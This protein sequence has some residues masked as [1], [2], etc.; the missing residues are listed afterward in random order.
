MGVYVYS[1]KRNEDMGK[2][3]YKRKWNIEKPEGYL[4]AL[5]T[6]LPVV[7]AV[8][9]VPL[10]MGQYEN[11]NGLMKYAWFNGGAVDYDFFL[12]W[13]SVLLSLLAFVM[14][15]CVIRR[16]VKEKKKA[17]FVKVFL[18]L[19][20]Y[21][22]LVFLS[23]CASVNKT[24]SFSG[25]FEQFESVWVL[26]SYV[27]IAY[28]VF[29]F[30]KSETELQVV[31]DA[32]CFCGTVVSLLGVLQA[33]GLDLFFA[34]WF[35]RLITSK[36]VLEQMGGQLPSTVTENYAVSTL[37]NSNYVGVFGSFM[38]PF[39]AM[40]LLFEKNK[41]RRIWHGVNVIL[42]MGVL[43]FSRSRAG[44]IAVVAALCVAVVFAFHKVIKWWFLTI[45]AV[46]LLVVLVL[47]V[48][49]YN[50]NIIFERLQNI[51]AKDPV[52][53]T[54]EVAEDGS[55]IRNTG[56]TEMYTTKNGVVF[57]YN[58]EQKKV[59]LYDDGKAFGFYT[60]EEDGTEKGLLANE[61]ATEF[62]FEEPALADV[63]V[64]PVY[65]GEEFGFKIKADGEWVF[66]Y[67][68]AKKKY[69]YVNRFQ[70]EGDMVMAEAFG[71]AEHQ[72]T[73]SGRGYIW[74][75]TI[76][77]LKERIFLG[78][79]PD[80]FVLEYP[81]NDYLMMQKNGFGGQIMTKPHSWY[82]QVGVQTGVLSLL[83][84][85]VFY[86]WYAICSMRLYAFRKLKTQTEAFGI[87]AFIGSIGF[88]IS[89]I[90]N[91]SMVVTSPVFWGVMGIGLTANYMVKKNR[92][93][94]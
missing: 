14:A 49:A 8:A 34:G 52:T 2:H 13:K 37:Y 69:Q 16:L 63:K 31:A 61:D 9:L 7:L 11:S 66:L 40:L 84:L 93:Q 19:F 82:L 6:M 89:G 72:R 67:N 81:Q 4:G 46:N 70:K 22:L 57:T 62:S 43:L 3:Y 42:V 20:G 53:V 44:L 21:G 55:V 5:V 76:P 80:T 23:A 26:L 10:I 75:R 64:L 47:L 73:F 59:A 51:F 30:A 85:L 71:F 60:V 45:P 83:C 68:E 32:V 77:L 24:F 1:Q 88:M 41:W 25:S 86:G 74:S 54:E 33:L 91:D 29:L 12:G 48:N 50:D 27:L 35:Q 92:E 28:Y 65:V 17:P 87:A 78:S 79:G 38:I 56:L 90:S 39:L 94:G 36:D 18:P 15:G 58:E